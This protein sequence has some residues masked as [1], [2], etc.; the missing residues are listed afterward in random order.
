MF[1]WANKSS[2]LQDHTKGGKGVLQLEGFGES[3][4]PMFFFSPYTS[5]LY[6]LPGSIGQGSPLSLSGIS[7]PGVG[8]DPGL[9]SL[10]PELPGELLPNLRG[11][12]GVLVLGLGPG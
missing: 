3:Q 11:G 2:L 12:L 9:A 7:L 4:V 5:P 8:S 6:G 1:W 10:G